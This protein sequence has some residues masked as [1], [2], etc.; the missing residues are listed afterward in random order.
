MI[1][2]IYMIAMILIY[3]NHGNHIN[4]KNHSSDIQQMPHFHLFGF[5]ISGIFYFRLN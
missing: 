2:M 5:Q 1:F 4:H 3:I